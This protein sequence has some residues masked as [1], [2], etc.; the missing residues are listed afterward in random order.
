MNQAPKGGTVGING[1]HYAGGQFLPNTTL[2]KRRQTTAKR[3]GPRR[4]L[5][6]PYTWEERPEGMRSLYALIAGDYAT[7]GTVLTRYEIGIAN[8]G[9]TVKRDGLIYGT[10]DELIARYNNGERWIAIPA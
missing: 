2:P 6:A 3:T 1:E 9:E 10:V 4:E 7:V 8:Y 5:I